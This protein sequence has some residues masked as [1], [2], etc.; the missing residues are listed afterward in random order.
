MLG[1]SMDGHCEGDFVK[2]LPWDLMG[3]LAQLD[4]ELFGRAV[5][6]WWERTFGIHTLIKNQRPL[7]LDSRAPDRR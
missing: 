1:R 2:L 4:D 3:V 6:T 7:P 5:G